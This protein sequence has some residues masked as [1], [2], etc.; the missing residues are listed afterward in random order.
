MSKKKQEPVDEGLVQA[1]EQ[2]ITDSLQQESNS[3]YFT[4]VDRGDHLLEG[5]YNGDVELAKSRKPFKGASLRELQRRLKEK[6]SISTMSGWLRLRVQH[7]ALLDRNNEEGVK[8]CDPERQCLL[9]GLKLSHMM[10][11]ARLDHTS[12]K[13]AYIQRIQAENWNVT[14]LKESLDDFLA[15]TPSLPKEFPEIPYELVEKTKSGLD[16]VLAVSVDATEELTRLPKHRLNEYS[17][18]LRTSAAQLEEILRRLRA[19]VKIVEGVQTMV[20][21]ERQ[22]FTPAGTEPQEETLETEGENRV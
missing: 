21:S 14:Q 3:N 20:G 18:K 19:S 13:I 12:L 6:V 22:A 9:G 16:D 10:Q 17:Q 1:S 4:D 5:F 8:W 15:K 2:Y 7:Q 11:L